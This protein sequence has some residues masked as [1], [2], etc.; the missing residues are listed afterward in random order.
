MIKAILKIVLI[1][2]ET[3]QDDF[4]NCL[5]LF[6]NRLDDFWRALNVTGN[7]DRGVLCALPQHSLGF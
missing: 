1:S 7:P 3:D 2:C 6:E 5:D 4:K